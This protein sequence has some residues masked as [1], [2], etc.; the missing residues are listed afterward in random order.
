MFGKN[1]EQDPDHELFVVFDSKGGFYG[2]PKPAVNK[3]DAMRQIENMFRNPKLR[4]DNPLFL[5]AE[6]YS[7][8]KI[9][10]YRKKNGDLRGQPPEH[11]ANLHELKASVLRLENQTGH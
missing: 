8:F 10:E 11:I 5:N 4:E 3:L 6:D 7:L 9:G 2:D 1:K